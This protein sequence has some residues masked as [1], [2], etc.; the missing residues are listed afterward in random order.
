MLN[1]SKVFNSNHDLPNYI[2]VHEVIT[3]SKV[4]GGGVLTCI[5]KNFEFKIKNILNCKDI[6]SVDVIY[7]NILCNIV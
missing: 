5:H 1:D 2:R 7:Q 6:E 3:H 4:V